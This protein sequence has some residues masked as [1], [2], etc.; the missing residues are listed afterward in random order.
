V[1]YMVIETYTRGAGRVY[2]R[3]A[4]RGRMLP[5]GLEYV[6]SWIEDG[7]LGRCFQLMETEDPSLF[8]QW[9]AKWSDLVDFEIVAVIGSAEAA[10]RVGSTPVEPV[11]AEW[12]RFTRPGFRLEFSYPAVSP[13]GQAVDR[14]EEHAVDHRGD[15]ERIHLSSPDRSELY[16]E[17]ARFRGIAPEDEYANHGTYLKQR[18]GPDEVTDLT[19]TSLQGRPARSYSFRSDEEGRP[20][21]RSA[22]LLHV[23]DDTYR[24][25]Y[26][27]RSA[28]NDEVL[29]T[30]VITD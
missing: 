22:L 3:A 7:T 25:I 16:V 5:P 2:A 28:L 18:F 11:P 27:P 13:R 14:T 10:R 29:A 19:S 23:G 4:E 21:E 17:V 26:D 12:E 24:V 20:M 1:R 9:V 8:D 30:I 15:I 6:E